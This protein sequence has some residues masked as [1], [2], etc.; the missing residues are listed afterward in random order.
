[1]AAKY[2]HV[3]T[4]GD[5]SEHH[6]KTT[7]L[8]S[9]P[10]LEDGKVRAKS[11]LVGL[12]SNNM[13][14]ATQGTRMHWWDTFPVPADLPSPFNNQDLYGI[15]PCW[16]YGE[17]LESRIKGIDTGRLIWGFWPSSDLP[18]DLKLT[19]AG[20]EGHYIDISEHRS[21]LMNAYQRYML[22]DPSLSA[23]SLDDE[24][25][26]EKLARAANCRAVWEAGYLINKAIFGQPPVHPVG[27]GE[28]SAETADLSSAV[29][30]SLSGSGRTARSFTDNVFHSHQDG[31]GPLAFL[32]ITSNP[33]A[34]IF[35]QPPIPT[36][37]VS[38]A[39]STT[40][41]TLEWIA[42]QK[43][44]KI[45]VVD[46]GGRDNAFDSLFSAIANAFSDLDVMAIGVGAEAKAH[47]AEDVGKLIQRNELSNRTMMNTTGIRDAMMKSLG[48]VEYWQGVE[49][50]WLGFLERG[51][52]DDLKIE[53]GEGVAGD[54]GFE[55]GWSDLSVGKLAV[56]GAKVYK[57]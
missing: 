3:V 52:V 49:K 11:L 25:V 16:G 18:V 6:V 53:V 13:A 7:S 38:Y 15:V 40:K 5:T 57:M 42:Q 54:R 32:A 36:T 27:V 20:I 50:A 41:S 39:D 2:V 48:E 9:L 26:F 4:K 19:K 33:K 1:M 35:R 44:K 21:Q 8:S 10:P 46:F 24:K 17:I 34:N 51:S 56:D 29:V 37:V 28:W 23:A 47:S 45:V 43:P 12:T 30:V 31:T 22:A 55:R 14:Y